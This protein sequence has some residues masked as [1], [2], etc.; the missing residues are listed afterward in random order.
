MIISEEIRQAMDKNQ[1]VKLK[2]VKVASSD[3]KTEQWDTD[4]NMYIQLVR[5]KS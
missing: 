5:I 2:V 3:S 1:N 4:R